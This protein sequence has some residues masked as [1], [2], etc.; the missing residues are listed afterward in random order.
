MISVTVRLA[1]SGYNF[2]V[3]I[4]LDTV[5]LLIEIL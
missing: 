2:N 1:G 4:F 3:T 5:T